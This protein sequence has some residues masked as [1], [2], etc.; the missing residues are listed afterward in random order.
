MPETWPESRHEASESSCSLLDFEPEASRLLDTSTD[1]KNDL[2]YFID[3][4][5]SVSEV[6]QV[7]RSMSDGQKYHLLKH[8]DKPS[9]KYL[10]PKQ[11]LGGAD[12]SFKLRWIEE[13]GWWLVYSSKLDSA[14]CICCTLFAQV[15]ERKNMGAMVNAPFRKWHHKSE[16]ITAHINK[17]SHIAASQAAEEFIHSIENPEKTIS[18]MLD[19]RKA[20]NIAENRHILKCVAE[21]ILYC[22]RQCIA[23]RG[24]KEQRD[25]PG[26]P[27]N[28]LSL[29]KLIANHDPKLKQHLDMPKLRNATTSLLKY[30][31]R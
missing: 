27:G 21:A 28:F 29:M 2:G 24:N 17:P 14:F 5:K 6:E 16:V 9:E 1:L 25:S 18:A 12:R 26:N 4:T 22:G 20:E 10:F 31:M 19:K 7:V 11:Y 13:C 30:R 8:H 15:K 3:A 23:L